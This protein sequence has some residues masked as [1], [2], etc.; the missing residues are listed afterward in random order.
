MTC[1]KGPQ[2]GIKPAA[3]AKRT[4]PLYM[5]AHALPGELPR[6]PYSRFKNVAYW[7]VST[8]L[9]TNSSLSLLYLNYIMLF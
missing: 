4:E 8:R 6:H 9:V 1:S 2:V 3:T 7:C 5:G